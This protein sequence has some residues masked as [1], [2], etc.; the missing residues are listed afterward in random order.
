LF[1]PLLDYGRNA[2]AQ[3]PF[4]ALHMDHRG[5]GHTMAFTAVQRGGKA[6]MAPLPSHSTEEIAVFIRRWID[7]RA[8][9]S[10]DELPAYSQMVAR[11]QVTSELTILLK[12]SPATMNVLVCALT[13]IRREPAC[14]SQAGHHGRL[15]LDQRQTSRS[16]SVRD[17]LPLEPPRRF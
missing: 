9:I 4:A 12:N 1:E 13:S 10:T 14:H 6:R 7:R 8:I 2:G 15:A 17:R 11:K 5:G 16:L 3:D